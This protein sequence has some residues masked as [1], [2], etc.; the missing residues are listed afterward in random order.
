MPNNAY[1]GK[2]IAPEN[3]RCYG[4]LVKWHTETDIPAPKKFE[5]GDDALRADEYLKLASEG[6]AIIWRGDFQNAK[7]LLQ[8]V[9]RRIK[10]PAADQNLS[11]KETF[12]KHRQQ[13]AHRARI[14]SR[15][16]IEID[17]QLSLP[18]KRSPDVKQPLREALGEIKGPFLLSLREL[19]GIIGASQWRAKGVH[20]QVLGEKIFPHYG[21]FAPVRQEYLELVKNAPLPASTKTAFDI[22]TGTGVLSAILA[23]RGFEKVIATDLDERAV[24]CA[25]ENIERLGLDQRIE[26]RKA[27]LFPEGKADLI[28]CNP[29]WVPARPTSRLETAIFDEKSQMLRAFLN[30][31]PA[32]L[33]PNGEAW[34]VISNF[35]EILGL[36]EE[37]DL[38]NW[39][40][41]AGLKLRETLEIKP[42]HPKAKDSGDLLSEYRKL[43]ITKL[44][45]LH[46]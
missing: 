29:P 13:R 33:N 22:G 25:K 6:T 34:L 36:R 31:A 20:V 32:H 26:I 45:R 7:Q 18:L 14:L 4:L 9:D 23:K 15:L 12:H 38:T 24:R 30:Q 46:L 39:M 3:G 8:A 5:N 37:N 21:T 28:V 11:T 17:D 35:A 27:N 44:F 43:E 1:Q 19:L 41:E 16:L 2:S 40:T 42:S 10:P